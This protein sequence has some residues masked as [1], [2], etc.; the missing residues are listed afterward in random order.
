MTNGRFDWRSRIDFSEK[1]RLFSQM[2]GDNPHIMAW[3]LQLLKYHMIVQILSFVAILCLYG[4]FDLRLSSSLAD[5]I[6]RLYEGK[7]LII[8]NSSL[9]N[10]ELYGYLYFSCLLYLAIFSIF[11]VSPFLF[12]KVRLRINKYE[13]WQNMNAIFLILIFANHI[14][15]LYLA[16]ARVQDTWGIL[17]AVYRAEFSRGV[18]LPVFS[19]PIILFLPFALSVLPVFIFTRRSTTKERQKQR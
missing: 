13:F 16:P 2:Q 9:E 11:Y 10:Y 8:K 7:G 4:L 6:P 12:F 17:N 14:R 15:L 5:M 3:F 1:V 18:L 19:A